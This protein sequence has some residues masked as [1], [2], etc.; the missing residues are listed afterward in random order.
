MLDASYGVLTHSVQCNSVRLSL[1][2]VGVRKFDK[3]MEI[4]VERSA[5]PFRV[6]MVLP[7]LIHGRADPTHLTVNSPHL[8]ANGR[9]PSKKPTH[10]GSMSLERQRRGLGLRCEQ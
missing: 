4:S 7:V 9:H 1:V 8:T 3:C 10:E 5:V 6:I 2:Q